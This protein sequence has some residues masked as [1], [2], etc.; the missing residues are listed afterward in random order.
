VTDLFAIAVQNVAVACLLAL[1]VWGLTRI[2]KNP[3][4]AHMLWVLVLVKLVTPPV[5]NFD[6]WKWAPAPVQRK[7]ESAPGVSSA[8]QQPTVEGVQPSASLPAQIARD[9]AELN[10]AA[11]AGPSA[12]AEQGASRAI[13]TLLRATIAAAWSMILPI[14]I[15]IWIGGTCLVALLVAIRIVRFH[16]VIAGTLPASQRLQSLADDLADRMGLRRPPNVR[17]V[18]SSV[19]P[20]LWCIGRRATVVLPRR[21]LDALDEHQ[22]AMVLTHE[23]AHLRRRDHWVRLIELVVSVLHWWNPLVWWVRRQLH[24]VEEQC[25][26]AWVAWVYPNR[27]HDYAESL[28]KAAD[29][30]PHHASFLVLASPFLHTYTLKERIEMVLK[31][32]SRRTASRRA[33]LVLVL[34]AAVVI[35]AGVHFGRTKSDA[36]GTPAFARIKVATVQPEA[37]TLTERYVCQIQSHRHIKVRALEIGYLE[38]ITIKEGQHVKAGDPLFKVI[39]ILYKKKADAEIAERALVQ[40]EYNYTKKQWENKVVSENE[41]RMLEAKL[42]KAE[43]KADL[44]IAELGFATVRAPF[45]GIVDRLPL[46]QGSLVQQGE[47]LTTLSDNSLMWVYFNVPEARYLE[48][49][50]AN[51]EQHQDDLKIELVLANGEKFDQPGKFGAISADFNNQTGNIPF[52]ADFANPAGL[53]RHGLTGTVLISRVQEGAIAIPQRATFEVGGRRYVYLVDKEGVAHQREIFVQNETA[54]DLFVV[55]TGLGSGDKIV[56]DGIRLV[57]D[58]DKVE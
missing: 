39:P 10:R 54:D 32:A 37:V 42:A 20:L 44:A 17:V 26:D 24:A 50:A 21:L 27:S 31:N 46:Q 53:L 43:A 45:D 47:T 1:L 19:A 30:S 29:L 5:V 34:F 55:K 7:I 48:Y 6:L 56:I 41:V 35:P 25:C 12:A 9:N 16:R 58:G 40:L 15:C 4:V 8:V 52:R 14:A 23:L 51:L 49:K 3:P 18:D 13:P 22:T 57:H 33:A 36:A 38:A 11:G 2:L 28:L